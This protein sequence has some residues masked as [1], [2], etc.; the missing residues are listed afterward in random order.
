MEFNVS[1]QNCHISENFTK[2]EIQE[3]GKMRN[4]VFLNSLSFFRNV[5]NFFQISIDSICNFM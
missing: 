3:F 5:G 2:T 4:L 1:E